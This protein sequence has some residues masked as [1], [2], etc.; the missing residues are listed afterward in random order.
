MKTTTRTYRTRR[1]RERGIALPVTLF[2]I[3]GL[4]IASTG[5][6]LIGTADI[7][8]TRN[9]RGAQQV[10]FVAES[11]LTH[12]LQRVNGV[13][14]IN[15]QNEVV[16][17]WNTFLGT[18]ARPMPGMAGYSYTVV[19]IANGGNPNN[20]GWLRATATG[21]EGVVNVA[22]AR[23]LRSNVPNTAPGAIYLATDGSSDTTFNGNNFQL[24]G[25]DY[26]LNGTAGPGAS[27]PGFSTRNETNTNEAI[28]SMNDVQKSN[29]TGLGYQAGS[30]PTPSV[31]TAPSAPSASQLDTMIDSLLALPGVVEF[32]D[33]KIVGSQTFGTAAAPQITH[34]TASKL[35]VMGAGAVTGYGIMIVEGDLAVLGT[36]NFAGLVLVRGGT[37]IGDSTTI[38]G[39]A[40]IYGSLW[41]N[42]LDLTLG[43]SALLRYS[44][45]GLSFANQVGGGGAFPAPLNVLGLINCQQVPPGADG[46]PA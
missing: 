18:A 36:L 27:V 40:S 37:T 7:Q 8:A 39:N 42:S 16:T 41:T 25:A 38:T 6:L 2:A 46:C 32:P 14:V 4:L 35:S 30:P 5:A 1:S 13:G 10:H 33:N 44:T 26:N 24:S 34:V 12:A 31:L 20:A 29:V 17:G 43:G 3:V 23:V 9:Y 11:G 45:E 21:P 28:A 22:V 15:F 19:P